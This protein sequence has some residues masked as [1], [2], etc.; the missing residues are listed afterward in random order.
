M[1]GN[2]IIDMLMASLSYLMKNHLEQRTVARQDRQFLN[3]QK[4]DEHEAEIK[5]NQKCV[6][7]SCGKLRK[8]QTAENSQEK[9]L[10]RHALKYPEYRTV[11]EAG[12]THCDDVT[13]LVA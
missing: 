7:L 10:P 8:K 5:K 11:A 4:I 9:P 2:Q 13:A 1:E 6:C 3:A 12:T